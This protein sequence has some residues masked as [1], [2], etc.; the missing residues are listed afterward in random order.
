MHCTH[1]HCTHIIAERVQLKTLKIS[2]NT[3]NLIL[4][5]KGSS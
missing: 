1:T 2:V 5:E 4:C 3:P